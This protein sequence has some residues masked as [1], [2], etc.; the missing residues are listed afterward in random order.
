MQFNA[1]H[2][3]QNYLI[4]FDKLLTFNKLKMKNLLFILSI[5]IL[6]CEKEDELTTHSG[7]YI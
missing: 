6:A 4:Y 2:S 1:L 5:F 7:I 3:N